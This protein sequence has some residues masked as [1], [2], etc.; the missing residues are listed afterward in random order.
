[1]L[2]AVAALG[3]FI[4]LELMPNAG[5]R[6]CDRIAQ[7]DDRELVY[8]LG[9]FANNHNR[10]RAVMMG[11]KTQSEICSSAVDSLAESMP[12]TDYRRVLE[13]I[14]GAPTAPVARSCMQ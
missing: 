14:A 6:A 3:L 4:V 1:M 10:A 11:R 7:L 5:T 13:C 8:D 9:H 2:A 12:S